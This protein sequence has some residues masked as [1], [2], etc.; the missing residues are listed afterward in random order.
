MGTAWKWIL[1]KGEVIEQ[2]LSGAP[3]RIGGMHQNIT[4]GKAAE[5]AQRASEEQ[6]HNI[7]NASADGLGVWRPD[8]TLVD[9]NPAMY[10]MN[11]YESREA[12]LSAPPQ[13]YIHPDSHALFAT[14]LEAI[15]CQKSFH[16]EG[17][18]L[19]KDG[20]VID[21]EV[22]GIP[23]QYQGAPHMLSIV[24]D[25]RERKQVSSLRANHPHRKKQRRFVL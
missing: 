5:H 9:A 20:C 2:D 3:L 16:E 22:H 8:G 17:T 7:F 12:F 1:T 13:Q 24:R 19:G 6:Y 14:F 15:K 4:R 25:I 18:I 10:R 21:V 11:G 23:I